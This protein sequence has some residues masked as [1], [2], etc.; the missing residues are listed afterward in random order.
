MITGQFPPKKRNGLLFHGSLILV[1]AIIAAWGFW[2]LSGVQ[3][4]PFFV[5]Y[6]L[7]GII[8][9]APIPM[10]GYRAYA[11]YRAQYRLDRNSLELRWGLRDELVP[12]SGIE[13][14]RSAKDLIHPLAL[15][16]LRM[17]GAVLGLRRHPDVGVIEFMASS[18]KDLLLV[19]APDKVYAISPAQAGEFMEAFGRAV[20]L[21]S[22][23]EATP[24]SLRASF[25]FAQAWQNGLVRYLWLAGLFLNIGLAAWISLLIPAS[26]RFALGFRPDG[27]PDAVASSQLVI[28]PLVSAF[29]G[30][31]GWVSGLFLYR[32]PKRRMLSLLVWAS[33]ALAALFFLVGVMFIVITPV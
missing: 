13:W 26:Q 17:P 22:L 1:L 16:A 18:S 20:E 10:L 12:L 21:G 6:L 27:T 11:L 14:V 15:P 9:F 5:L 3:A 2:Q 33:S 29:L 30:L 23:K 4:G 7:L 28:V 19:A 32:W 31:V 24:R 8:S 25:V